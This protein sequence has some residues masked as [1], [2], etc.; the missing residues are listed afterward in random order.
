[1]ELVSRARACRSTSTRS[2]TTH[3]LGPRLESDALS[4]ALAGASIDHL[5]RLSGGASRETWSFDADGRPLI[6]RRDP[7]GR[8][9]MPGSMRREADAMRACVRAGL[10]A[11]EV[12]M[13]DDGS[14]LGTAGLVMARVPGETLARRILRDDE[15]AKAREV[16]VG[17]L[18]EL[19]AGFHA[20]DAAEVPG[21]EVTD[22]LT[23][24]WTSYEGVPDRSPTFEKAYAWLLDNRP[25]GGDVT[26]V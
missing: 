15:Y 24:Y 10:R 22:E 4:K 16:L 11:P 26:L 17:Q 2:S 5:T 25:S 21:A 1:M 19:L 20:I 9:G 12:L 14:L 6:L 13:D 23:R 3:R 7:P 8:P 18:G